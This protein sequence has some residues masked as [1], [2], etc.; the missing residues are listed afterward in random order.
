M[1]A[2]VHSG[3]HHKDSL[4]SYLGDLLGFQLNFVFVQ[5][6]W[7]SLANCMTNE[8]TRAKLATSKYL[9]AAFIYFNDIVQDISKILICMTVLANIYFKASSVA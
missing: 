8:E 1:A 5:V 3:G 2:Q 6:F 7:L 4:H 9:I